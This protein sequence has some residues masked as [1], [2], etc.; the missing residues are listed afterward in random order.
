MPAESRSGQLR[1]QRRKNGLCMTCGL[2]VEPDAN[3]YRTA[4]CAECLSKRRRQ[5]IHQ[6]QERA[7]V[8]ANAQAQV[9]QLRY[10]AEKGQHESE[11]QALCLVLDLVEKEIASV[12]MALERTERQ[13]EVQL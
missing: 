11:H 13:Q 3:G 6:L 1:A 2:A 7:E 8:L 4:Q 12:K 10:S 5:K 9:E